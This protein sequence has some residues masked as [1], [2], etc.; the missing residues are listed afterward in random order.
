VARPVSGGGIPADVPLFKLQ[1]TFSEGGHN[2][3]FQTFTLIKERLHHAREMGLDTRR[4]NVDL[5]PPP[6]YSAGGEGVGSAE[7]VTTNVATPATPQQIASQV[8]P[9]NEPP[10]GYEEAQASAGR[11]NTQDR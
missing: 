3:F 4:G 11:T 1:F 2:D 9:P 7:P 8:P 10:P 6:M 5:E